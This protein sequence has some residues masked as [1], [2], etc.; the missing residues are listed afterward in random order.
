MSSYELSEFSE[1]LIK[2]GEKYYANELVE[3]I[4]RYKV[5]EKMARVNSEKR[6]YL[7]SRIEQLENDLCWSEKKLL[8]TEEKNAVLWLACIIMAVVIIVKVL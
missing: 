4:N 2:N 5:Y 6:N 1:K 3:I 7:S 8:S